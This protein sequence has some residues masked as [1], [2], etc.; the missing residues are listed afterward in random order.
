LANYLLSLSSFSL[1]PTLKREKWAT[2]I[3][4]KH[5]YT[6][7]EEVMSSTLKKKHHKH[8]HTKKKKK[9]KKKK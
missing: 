9:K 8:K 5:T 2:P 1:S 6:Y 7:K 4:Q 3:T